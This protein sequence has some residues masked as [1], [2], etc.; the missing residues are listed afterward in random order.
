[1]KILN[2]YLC[3]PKNELLVRRFQK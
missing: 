1:M 2:M 3:I